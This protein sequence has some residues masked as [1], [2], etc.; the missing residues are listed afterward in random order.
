MNIIFRHT[1]INTDCIFFNEKRKNIIINGTF[2]KIIYSNKN[3]SLNG[4]YIIFPE[5]L[6]EPPVDTGNKQ[7]N[8]NMLNHI[9]DLSGVDVNA[10]II[11]TPRVKQPAISR[12]PSYDEFKCIQP[13]QPNHLNVYTERN[14]N[15]NVKR[16]DGSTN[17]VNSDHSQF[18]YVSRHNKNINYSVQNKKLLKP[19]KLSNK[20]YIPLQI[21]NHYSELLFQ[22]FCNMEEKILNVYKRI[23]ETDKN[24]IY[25]LKNQLMTGFIHVSEYDDYYSCEPNNEQP[26]ISTDQIQ[27]DLDDDTEMAIHAKHNFTQD[28][29]N[30][31]RNDGDYSVGNC[32]GGVSNVKYSTH[33]GDYIIKISGVWETQHN[34]GITY[35]F[36]HLSQFIVC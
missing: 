32:V 33:G 17:S 29:T 13:S 11:G 14:D 28:N 35:K 12:Y 19:S 25:T 9:L 16:I 8:T 36:I 34:I 23:N 6:L 4:I 26:I 1:Q 2:S 21:H 7:L 22:Y 30:K 18:I 24:I 3:V 10:N 20:M 27:L 15:T 31:T 5:E